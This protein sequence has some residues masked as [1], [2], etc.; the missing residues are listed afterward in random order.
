MQKPVAAAVAEVEAGSGGAGEA[1][2][3]GG[4]PPQRQR[5]ERGSDQGRHPFF[6]LGASAGPGNL[7]QTSRIGRIGSDRMDAVGM[8]VVDCLEEDYY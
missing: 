4:E 6:S 8:G 5:R 3:E 7:G 1:G 2:Q